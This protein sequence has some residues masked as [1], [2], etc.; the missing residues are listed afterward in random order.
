MVCPPQ[1]RHPNLLVYKDT[2][3]VDERGEA[4]IY[5][6]TEPVKPLDEALRDLRLD[7]TQRCVAFG[8]SV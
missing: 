1:L 3:E 2:A 5:L 7:G 8:W 4:V 6:V